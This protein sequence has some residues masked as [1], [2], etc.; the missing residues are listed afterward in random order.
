MHNLVIRVDRAPP[1]NRRG[2]WINWDLEEAMDVLE[3]GITTLKRAS[4]HWNI[5]I[6][7]LLDHLNGRTRNRKNRF[8]RVLTYEE[9]VTLVTW[10]LTK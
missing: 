7:S 10:K 1:I 3:R 8:G 9:D 6:C 2:K 4:R 5:P